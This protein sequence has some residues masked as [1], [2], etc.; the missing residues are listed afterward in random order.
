MTRRWLSRLAWATL[1]TLMSFSTTYMTLQYMKLQ[2]VLLPKKLLTYTVKVS[3]QGFKEVSPG[4]KQFFSSVGA[5][6]V[7]SEEG[8]V[9]TAAHVVDGA[10]GVKVRLF[11]DRLF[12]AVVV[13]S[14]KMHDLALLKIK[15]SAAKFKYSRF[16]ED[17]VGYGLRVHAVG[18]PL[19]MQW[20]VTDGK[21]S[22]FTDMLISSVVSNTGNS[23]GG[24]FDVDGRLVGVTVA[25]IPPPTVFNNLSEDASVP[26]VQGWCGYTLHVPVTEV[27][28]FLWR[29]KNKIASKTL[30][31]VRPKLY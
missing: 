6:V 30:K 15:G 1:L 5:G 31:I 28:A 19:N 10:T 18:F 20:I 26:H 12:D 2:D 9:I 14:A 23:G 21:I 8:Y 11:D 16:R 24:L 7:V 4:V 3:S 17:A 22:G 29:S 27:R 25:I 13:D